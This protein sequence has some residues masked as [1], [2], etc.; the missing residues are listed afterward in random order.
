MASLPPCRTCILY[1]HLA[2]WPTACLVEAA[3]VGCSRSAVPPPP[4]THHQHLAGGRGGERKV[5]G[6]AEAHTHGYGGREGREG[7]EGRA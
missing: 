1:E 6:A 2:G 4:R 3:V 5:K 7:V